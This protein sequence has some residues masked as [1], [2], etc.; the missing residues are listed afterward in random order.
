M[1][2]YVDERSSRGG[3]FDESN[4]ELI[5]VRIYIFFSSNDIWAKF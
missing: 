3:N 1:P 5:K 4:L 2:L